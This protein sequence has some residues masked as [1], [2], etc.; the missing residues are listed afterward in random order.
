MIGGGEPSRSMRAKA[1]SASRTVG[2]G[3]GT[4]SGSALRA[5]DAQ[6]GTV[7]VIG[8]DLPLLADDLDPP[9]R[10]AVARD[11]LTTARRGPEKE[12][13]AA[14]L[15]SLR[16]VTTRRVSALTARGFSPVKKRSRVEAVD[17]GVQQVA[18][19]RHARIVEPVEERGLEALRERQLVKRAERARGRREPLERRS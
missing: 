9:E 13:T 5:G 1:R 19:A 4:S 6:R 17:A 8:E 7:H 12:K 2:A 11:P 15:S 18:A 3:G 14:K 10:L 16:R